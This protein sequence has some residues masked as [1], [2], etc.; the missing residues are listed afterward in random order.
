MA[1][2]VLKLQVTTFCWGGR[3]GNLVTKSWK[4]QLCGRVWRLGNLVT[5]SWKEQ[6]CG[7]VGTT[8]L[9]CV[10]I[11]T[12]TIVNHNFV[13]MCMIHV[14]VQHEF[15]GLF[16]DCDLR[17]Q[18]LKIVRFKVATK[19]ATFCRSYDMLSMHH[20]KLC[21]KTKHCFV[22]L[23]C[24]YTTDRHIECTMLKTGSSPEACKTGPFRAP[25]KERSSL[26]QKWAERFEQSRRFLGL[27]LEPQNHDKNCHFYDISLLCH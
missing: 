4:E 10:S 3:L 2:R 16:S 17:L 22:S 1:R 11:R 20:N 21:I 19:N 27:F 8:W 5:K 6:L 18:I 25:P 15:H 7:R 9:S 24:C 13:M 26:A 14:V 23:S 12:V